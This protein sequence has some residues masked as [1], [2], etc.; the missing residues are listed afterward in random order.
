MARE[1]GKSEPA[2]GLQN[3]TGRLRGCMFDGLLLDVP[4]LR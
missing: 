1:P 4:V 2:F 3:F